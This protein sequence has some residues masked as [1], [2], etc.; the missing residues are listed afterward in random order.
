M[1]MPHLHCLA[2]ENGHFDIV[3]HIL[4]NTTDFDLSHTGKSPLFLAAEN[5]YY[6]ILVLLL[7]SK[8]NDITKTY[9]D[10]TPLEIAV[11]K[12][13]MKIVQLLIKEENKLQKYQGNN[14]LFEILS[15]LKRSEF[16]INEQTAKEDCQTQDR[17]H[18]R[19]PYTMPMTT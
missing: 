13:R 2:V 12:N 3:K 15:D 4:E 11:W 8:Y 10:T 1:M 14:R 16:C 6:D 18:R 5:G 19:L 7:H 9:L 17:N